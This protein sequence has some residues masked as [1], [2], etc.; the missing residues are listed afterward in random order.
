LLEINSDNTLTIS[1]D[2]RDEDLIY[3]KGPASH[4]GWRNPDGTLMGQA[5]AGSVHQRTVP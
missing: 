5:T 3:N 2:S 4:K 1:L